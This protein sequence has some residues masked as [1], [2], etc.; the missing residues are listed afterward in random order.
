M[1]NWINTLAE[2][3]VHRELVWVRTVGGIVSTGYLDPIGMW[4]TNGFMI[5]DPFDAVVM[6]AYIDYPEVPEWP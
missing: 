5:L 3:P 2:L 4:V 1:P 6:W